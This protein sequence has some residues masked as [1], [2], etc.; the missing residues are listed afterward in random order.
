MAGTLLGKRHGPHLQ[1][2]SDV[3]EVFTHPNSTQFTVGPAVLNA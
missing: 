1:A 2:D 3:E